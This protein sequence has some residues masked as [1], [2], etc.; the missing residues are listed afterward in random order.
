LHLLSE[1]AEDQNGIKVVKSRIDQAQEDLEGLDGKGDELLTSYNAL[2]QNLTQLNPLIE[3]ITELQQSRT[4]KFPS[5]DYVNRNV[6]PIAKEIQQTINTML[7]SELNDL[8]SDRQQ[9]LTDMLELQKN[10]V[11]CDQQFTWLYWL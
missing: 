8:S 6:L 11:K 5:F 10:L 9:L 1:S 2:E 4:K 3:Q 7:D